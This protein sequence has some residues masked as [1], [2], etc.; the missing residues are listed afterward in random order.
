[1]LVIEHDVADARLVVAALSEV[2][3]FDFE[4]DFATNI[5]DAEALLTEHAFEIVLLDI[6]LP[7]LPWQEA[8]DRIAALGK[9]SVIMIAPVNQ[10]NL[11][12]QAVQHGAHDYVLKGS[13]RKAE[14]G[15]SIRYALERQQIL[16]ESDSREERLKAAVEAQKMWVVGRLAATVA[17]EFNNLLTGLIGDAELLRRGVADHEPY[18][19][20]AESLSEGL[21]HAALLTHQ[22]VAFSRKGMTGPQVMDMDRMVDGLL[23][24]LQGLLGPEVKFDVAR[25]EEEEITTRFRIELPPNRVTG[26]SG[27]FGVQGDIFAKVLVVEDEEVVRRL[28]KRVLTE[29]GYDVTCAGD[30]AEALAAAQGMDRIDLLVTDVVMPHMNGRDLNDELRTRHPDMKT[31]FMSGYDGELVAPDGELVEGK[32]FLPKPFRLQDMLKMVRL[33]LRD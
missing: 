12:L 6:C 28:L 1:M 29:S 13:L 25:L 15:R 26:P 10:E 19:T 4:I 9:H 17:H 2:A 20:Y 21:A 33:T 11:G 14:L 22:L 30:G 23:P 18:S 31:L 32:N 7:D 5:T 3:P 27:D 16:S 8:V 24:V